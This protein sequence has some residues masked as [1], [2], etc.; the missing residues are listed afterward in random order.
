MDNKWQLVSENDFKNIRERL[1]SATSIEDLPVIID[2][3]CFTKEQVYRI[4]MEY[5]FDKKVGIPLIKRMIECMPEAEKICAQMV[6]NEWVS[7]K[8]FTT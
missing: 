1:H 8:Y 2:E 6:A 7:K 4:L 5:D 3:S